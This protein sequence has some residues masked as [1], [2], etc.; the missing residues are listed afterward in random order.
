MKRSARQDGVAPAVADAVPVDPRL[1]AGGAR[2]RAWRSRRELKAARAAGARARA[3]ARGPACRAAVREA[4]AAHALDVPDRGARARRRRDRAAGRR[5]A[6]R[7]RD[8]SRTSRATSSAGSHGAV[9][10]TFA[11]A[12]LEAFADAAPRLHVVNALT[13]EEH[14]CQ[15]L[16]DCLTLI[17]R[18]GIAARPHDRV[19]RRR[20]QRRDLARAGRRRCSARTCAI[21][22]PKGFELPASVVAGIARVAR[23]GGTARARSTDPVAAVR[24]A[25]AVYTD[26]WTS[27]GQEAEA[28]ERR[29]DLRAVPGER[30]R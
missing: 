26:V 25:D 6:R 24:G 2:R 15:A 4:V 22:S 23:H 8:R 16:A 13:D 11:Q 1:R 21:A 12:R 14:P 19:R 5:R 9:V 20:Q 17:E 3:A 28:A 18:W 27:M 30:A 29:R 10:R 7:T